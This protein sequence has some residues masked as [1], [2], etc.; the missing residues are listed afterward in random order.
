MRSVF[1]FLALISF[2]NLYGNGV[3]Q[4]PVYPVAKSSETVL[5]NGSWE[6]K[7]IAGANIPDE[8]T[9]FYRPGFVGKNWGKIDV[10]SNWELQGKAE[11]SYAGIK[12]GFGLYRTTFSV[13]EKFPNDNV[14]IRFEGV[15]YAYELYVNGNFVGK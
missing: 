10:P 15:L 7:Y 5:L 2:H 4:E 13:P 8:D 14:F 1:L 3:A 6:F 11:T 9:A 12:E